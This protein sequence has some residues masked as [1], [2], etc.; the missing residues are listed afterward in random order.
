[1][2]LYYKRGETELPMV[3]DKGADEVAAAIREQ[4]RQHGV[5]LVENRALARRLHR[6]VPID[7]FIPAD[8][9]ESVAMIFRWINQLKKG[10]ER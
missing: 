5:P 9:I 10:E 8:L 3:V 7:G 4:A 1:M 6:D 2:A